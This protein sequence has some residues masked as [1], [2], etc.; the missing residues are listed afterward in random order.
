[1]IHILTRDDALVAPLLHPALERVEATETGPQALVIAPDRDSVFTLAAAVNVR[2]ERAGFLL[3]PV[4]ASPRGERRLH[5]GARAICATA[6]DL[7]A[8]MAKALFKPEHLRSV[9]VVW[10]DEQLGEAM[11][12]A[13]ETVLTQVPR[14]ADRMLLVGALHEAVESFATGFLWRARRMQHTVTPT[15]IA[16]AMEYAVCVPE[17]RTH[18]VRL[19]LERLDPARPV[20]V[21]FSDA[22]ERDA[23]AALTALGYDADGSEECR[24]VRD[25]VDGSADL[26]LIMEIPHDLTLL[27]TARGDATRAVVL[28]PPAQL[29]AVAAALGEGG[30]PLAVTPALRDAYTARDTLRDEILGTLR[31]RP[32]TSEVL[33]LEAIVAERDP[34]LVAA[35]LWRLL[36]TERGR[37]RKS[38]TPAPAGRTES[39]ATPPPSRPRGDPPRPSDGVFTRLFINVGERDGMRRGDLVGA[40]TGEGGIDGSQI[41]K[42]ELRDTHSLVEVARDVAEQVVTRLTGV[43]MRGRKVVARVDGGR[44]AEERPSRGRD[45]RPPRRDA[46]GKRGG[47]GG[48][49]GPSAGG[50]R[51]SGG[52]DF[53]GGGK[54]DEGG[55]G[56]RVMR[57]SEEW[58][59][60]GDRL[61]Q[62]RPRRNDA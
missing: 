48:G 55:R 57:E 34:V 8:L 50:S 15:T 27:A 29:V 24:I 39:M 7:V 31:G 60:R 51:G 32:V 25:R 47:P 21:V 22:G 45:E 16:S 23:R 33:A 54:R 61:R 59:S 28:V 12:P 41:G 3:V 13:L 2:S 17:A 1:M 44:P 52:R 40:I 56:P 20:A 19:V 58:G 26:A 30:S 6:E 35:A 42:I 9:A 36:E 53:G 46:G 11:R 37:S 5:A 49:R 14:D 62:S 43:S 38:S 4:V 18:V 10:A